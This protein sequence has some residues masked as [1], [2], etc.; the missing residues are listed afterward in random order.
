MLLQIRERQYLG[1]AECGEDFSGRNEYAV[2]RRRFV[3]W[4]A[5]AGGQYDRSVIGGHFLV[6]SVQLRFIEVGAPDAAFLIVRHQCLGDAAQILKGVD[7][8]GDP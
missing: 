5:D 1:V 6:G 8:T 2:F 4:F 7:M 3:P